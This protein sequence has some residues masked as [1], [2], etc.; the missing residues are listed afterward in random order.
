MG[1][2]FV[3]LCSMI[4]IPGVK[5]NSLHDLLVSQ[6]QKG[7]AAF[8]YVGGLRVISNPFKGLNRLYSEMISL[9]SLRN[10]YKRHGLNKAKFSF[11][12]CQK[13]NQRSL[14]IV[15]TLQRVSTMKQMKATS[16]PSYR[17]ERNLIELKL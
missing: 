3:S 6:T 5:L 14:A 13:L 16:K 12:D 11:T 15:N 8:S 2:Y 4:I 10:D 7:F 17:L 1:F 9:F